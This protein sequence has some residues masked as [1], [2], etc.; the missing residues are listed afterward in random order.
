MNGVN[1]VIVAKN[2]FELDGN[3]VLS[4][5]ESYEKRKYEGLE[6]SRKKADQ[7]KKQKEIK[8]KQSILK[9]ILLGFVIGVTI[10]AR[11]CMIYNYQSAAAKTK[12]EIGILNKENDAYKVELIKF[13]NISYVEKVAVGRLNMVK[14]KYSDIQ[15]LDL[16][17]NNLEVKKELQVK[18]STIIINKLK[19][20][21]F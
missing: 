18:K 8:K 19:N 2:K 9:Y 14:P 12:A 7:S 4:P 13:R 10:I 11:Y 15:Y 3:T 1:K 17:K 21:I 5:S 6:E 20:I 16:S